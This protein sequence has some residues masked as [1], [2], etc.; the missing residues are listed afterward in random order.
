MVEGALG[1][2]ACPP[3]FEQSHRRIIDATHQQ[4]YAGIATTAPTR[5]TSEGPLHHATRQ[6]AAH[7]P[8]PPLRFAASLRYAGEDEAEH[9]PEFFYSLLFSLI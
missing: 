2:K 8:P 5:G 3:P 9:R 6:A 4:H 7:D 1:L